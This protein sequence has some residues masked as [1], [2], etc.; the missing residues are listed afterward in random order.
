MNRT[1]L[2]FLGLILSL[3]AAFLGPAHLT[4]IAGAPLHGWGICQSFRCWTARTT[5]HGWEHG[6]L[7]M[8]TIGTDIITSPTS[9]SA[10]VA[11]FVTTTFAPP[12]PVTMAVANATPS[13]TATFAPPTTFAPPAPVTMTVATVAPYVT[14]TVARLVTAISA[15]YG[16]TTMTVA[17]AVPP[18]TTTVAR[19]VTAISAPL[20]TRRC[21]SHPYATDY[22]CDLFGCGWVR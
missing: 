15:P 7:Y 21:D 18:I 16:T 3:G 12:A 11:R 17:T 4:G 10:T 14:M 8:T 5:I 19:L 13:V 2:G 6:T 9:V 20:V 1:R 22:R